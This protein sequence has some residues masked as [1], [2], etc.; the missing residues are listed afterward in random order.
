MK[1][2]TPGA[3]APMR[4]AAPK[5]AAPAPARM[6]DVWRS[7]EDEMQLVFDRF[8]GAFNHPPD[9]PSRLRG[10]A[11]SVRHIRDSLPERPGL[12][13]LTQLLANLVFA[14]THCMLMPAKHACAGRVD[15]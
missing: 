7:L 1:K 14:S 5:P 6:P 10:S 9:A 12:L 13:D 4:P 11:F 8:T 2:T 15:S 3:A